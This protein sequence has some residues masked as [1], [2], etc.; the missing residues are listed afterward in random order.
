MNNGLTVSDRPK[1]LGNVW[2]I[3]Y[4]VSTNL[5]EHSFCWHFKANLFEEDHIF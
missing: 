4:G 2:A 3:A 5:L 1:I